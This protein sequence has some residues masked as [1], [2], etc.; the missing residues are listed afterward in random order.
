VD[1]NNSEGKVFV[2]DETSISGKG[3]RMPRGKR[4]DLQQGKDGRKGGRRIIGDWNNGK[5]EV[6]R[7]PIQQECISEEGKTGM[8]SERKGY[9]RGRYI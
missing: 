4:A 5:E 1:Q 3:I 8:G 2:Q 7:A 6:E 9:K